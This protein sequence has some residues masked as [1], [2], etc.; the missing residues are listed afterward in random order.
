MQ[1][2]SGPLQYLR[3]RLAP[4]FPDP[5]NSRPFSRYSAFF[6]LHFALGKGGTP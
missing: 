4:I 3:M 1:W 5:L 6:I 2:L